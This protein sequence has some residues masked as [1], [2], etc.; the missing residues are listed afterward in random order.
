MNTIPFYIQSTFC[1]DTAQN[2]NYFTEEQIIRCR[3]H[4]AQ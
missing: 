1:S 2:S 4:Q 3:D